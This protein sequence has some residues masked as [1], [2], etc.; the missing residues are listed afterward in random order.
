MITDDK[1]FSGSS[2]PAG[3]YL[4]KIVGGKQHITKQII[5]L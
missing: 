4:V 2:G 1:R 5:K 3:V